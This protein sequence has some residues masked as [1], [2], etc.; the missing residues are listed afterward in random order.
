[1]WAVLVLA[2]GLRLYGLSEPDYWLDELHSQANSAARRA[3]FESPR[4]DDILEFA[5][6]TTELTAESTWPAVWRGMTSDS[7]PPTYF[8]LLLSW[9]KVVGDGEF[10]VRLLPTFFS[11]L[12]LVPLALI[13]RE[14]RRPMVGVALA[15]LLAVSFS[16]IRF[17]QDNRPYSLAMLL[18]GASYWMFIKMLVGWDRFSRRE[19]WGWAMAYGMATYLS[20]MTHYFTG[21][22]LAGQAVLMATH[23]R[24]PFRRA[25]MIMVTATILAFGVTWGPQLIE[26]WS[27]IAGQEA[28]LLDRHSGHAL[29]TVLRLADVP[30]RLLFRHEPFEP[31]YLRSLAGAVVLGGALVALKRRNDL[32]AKLF[33]VW[34]VMPVMLFATIDLTTGTRLL[35]QMRYVSIA[36]PGLGGLVVIAASRLRGMTGWAVIGV[37]GLALVLTLHLPT[38]VNPRGRRA[39]KYI[40]Q[41]WRPGDLL[42]FDGIGWPLHWARHTYQI[43]AYY[44]PEYTMAEPPVALI[45]EPPDEDLREAMAA[46]N[47]IIVVSPRVGELPNPVPGVFR[48]V[49]KTGNVLFMGEIHLFE[50]DHIEQPP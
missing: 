6:R 34:Y 25:W 32:A 31:E 3:E 36:T 23:G 17:A 35:T 14:F 9:R 24:G 19:R 40:A 44:L 45:S 10:V 11:I 1:L 2:A 16:H 50:R 20:V 15:A 41:Q 29:R 33:A 8:L 48:H 4:H 30:I 5:P 13:L 26:Q 49:D 18:L 43:A 27:L 39:A 7:H 37:V 28:W 21:P 38:P 46:F 47:R 12:S 22:A 42:V